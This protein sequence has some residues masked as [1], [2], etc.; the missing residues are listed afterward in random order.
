MLVDH[1]IQLKNNKNIYIKIQSLSVFAVFFYFFNHQNL[2]F[3]HIFYI[4]ENQNPFY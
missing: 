2:E 3:F 4:N 1:F